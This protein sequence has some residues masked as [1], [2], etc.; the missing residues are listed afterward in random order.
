MVNA[1]LRWLYLPEKGPGTSC[2]TSWL[3]TRAD[4]GGYRK[5]R[6]LCVKWLDVDK[7]RGRKK[8]Q[9]TVVE[10]I[11]KDEMLSGGTRN[12]QTTV[13]KLRDRIK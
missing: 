9:C 2:T 1:T 12:I 5:Y 11:L 3:G 13:N 8:I 6:T 7:K 4:L 10:V